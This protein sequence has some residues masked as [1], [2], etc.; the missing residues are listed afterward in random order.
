MDALRKL[1]ND[2]KRALI[3]RWVK[4]SD[5]VLDCGCGRGGDLHKWKASGAIVFAIDPD[6]AS[7]QEAEERAFSIGIGVWFLRSRDDHPGGICRSL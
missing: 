3:Q 2:C 7:L 6:E 4:R 1:H 5:R